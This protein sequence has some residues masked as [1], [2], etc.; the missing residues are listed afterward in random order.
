HTGS[1]DPT[2]A[3]RID[4]ETRVST[5][6]CDA[7]MVGHLRIQIQERSFGFWERKPHVR[8]TPWRNTMDFGRKPDTVLELMDEGRLSRRSLLKRSA[9]LG[10]AIP[11]MSGLIAACGNDDDDPPAD[12]AEPTT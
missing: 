4:E 2:M 1:V 7:N 11:V 10:L 6:R 3:V 9:A 5:I 12:D 8:H